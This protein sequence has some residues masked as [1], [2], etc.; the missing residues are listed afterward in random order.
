MGAGFIYLIIVGLWI[1]Y[2]LPRWINAH[3][4]HAGRS[5][6]RYQAMLDV[7]GRTATGEERVRFT[8]EQE[9]QLIHT[10]RI[11][12]LALASLLIITLFLSVI[13]MLSAGLISVPI[14]GVAAYVIV[15]RRQITA[16]RSSREGAVKYDDSTPSLYRSKYAELITRVTVNEQHE[17]W[18]PLAERDRFQSKGITLL[19]RGSAAR[20]SWDP[21]EVP[22]PSYLTAPKVVQ[23]RRV[24]DLTN[25]GAWSAANESKIGSNSGLTWDEASRAALAPSPDEIFDQEVAEEVAERIEQLRRAN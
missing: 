20:G 13:G 23:T 5:V 1:A 21:I 6:D 8:P 16:Q 4:E 15:V 11:T 24:I 12:F 19:P 22:T 2:F 18:T 3:E 7:V 10:R 25:P 14:V 17:E 9:A